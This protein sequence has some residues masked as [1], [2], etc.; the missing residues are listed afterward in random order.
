MDKSRQQL[1]NIIT[2]ECLLM[3]IDHR[4]ITIG[5]SHAEDMFEHSKSLVSSVRLGVA[6]ARIEQKAFDNNLKV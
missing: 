4:N 1:R 3:D 5:C 6:V 2:N